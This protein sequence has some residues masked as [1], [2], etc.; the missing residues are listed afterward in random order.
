MRSIRVFIALGAVNA[1]LAVSAGALGA[2]L[3]KGLSPTEQSTFQTATLYHLFHA[4]GLLVVALLM[5]VRP[6]SALLTWAGVLMLVGIVAFCG[7][8]YLS[9]V[10]D[11]H[12]AT[13]LAP[14][15]G[16]AFMTAWLLVGLS[17][18]RA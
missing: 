3:L 15:G 9:A 14:F 13:M 6:R 11:V 1:F 17:S 16:I 8:L 12:N 18:L 4:I 5:A 7:S 2:H 10:T